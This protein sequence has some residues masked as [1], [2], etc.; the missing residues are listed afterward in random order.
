MSYYYPRAAMILRVLFEDGAPAGVPTAGKEH[1]MVVVPKRVT[2]NINSYREADTFSCELDY[3]SFPFDPRSIRALGVSIFIRDQKQL[4]DDSGR[5]IDFNLAVDSPIAR[6][7]IVFQGFADLEKMRFNESTRT[8]S[9]EGRDFTAILIDRPYLG[10]PPPL[11][12]SVDAIITDLL[13]QLPEAKGIT[14]VNRTGKDLPVLAKYASDFT[15]NAK[16]SGH[17]NT[18]K[19]SK[20]W[21]LIQ[22]LVDRS[23]LI[24][25]IEID[26]LVISEPRVLYNKASAKQFIYGKNL[27]ELDFERKLGRLKGFNIELRSMSLRDKAV[28]IVTARVP[29]EATT[30]WASSMGIARE[31]VKI[32]RKQADGTF[33]EEDAPYYVFSVPDMPDKQQLIQHAQRVFEEVGRQEIEGTLTTRDMLVA[34]S[35]PGR[36]PFDV[37]KIRNGT[38]IVVHIDDQDLT[39]VWSTRSEEVRRRYL[40]SRGYAEGVATSLATALGKY[41]NLFYTRS[42][43]FTVDSEAGFDCR[44]QFI[45]FIVTNKVKR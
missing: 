33:K 6:Q 1:R 21:E 16:L 14:V 7:S 15:T 42:V 29:E 10:G 20:Y 35:A 11:T 36:V 13:A 17:K 43:E 25:Y 19:D 45:N 39:E 44:L 9:F 12:K 23:A 38:P 28:G 4:Y 26:K 3:K 41:E 27:K 8:T 5:L 40:I 22:D 24:A 30:D 2:V 32:P 18:R 37:T 34:E 31:K